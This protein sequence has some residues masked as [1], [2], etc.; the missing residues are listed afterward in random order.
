ML[1]ELVKP[2][3]IVFISSHLMGCAAQTALSKKDLMEYNEDTNTF[4]KSYEWIL[5]TDGI[6]MGEVMNFSE[7]DTS[8]IYCNDINEMNRIFGIEVAK[9]SFMRELHDCLS[10]ASVGNKHVSLLA[11]IIIA[12]GNL[13]S[14][15]RHGINKSDIGPLA[16]CSFEETSEQLI[17]AG[18]FADYDNLKGVS[19]NIMLGQIPQCGTG[20][21]KILLDESK[22]GLLNM[23]SSGLTHYNN[24]ITQE[25]LDKC[26]PEN[27]FD[28]TEPKNYPGNYEMEEF[29]VM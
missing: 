5:Q 27:L 3:M 23:E 6:N 16:K 13:L 28:E 24:D 18:L 4:E 10:G 29:D 7:V 12:R 15:D 8:R 22:L 2:I 17:K 19:A 26:V 11:D 21:S 9:Q 14:I 25:M 1:K 20:D